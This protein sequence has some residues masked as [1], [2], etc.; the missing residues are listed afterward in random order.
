MYS[1]KHCFI[2]PL[3]V[4]VKRPAMGS[5]LVVSTDRVRAYRERK[6]NGEIQLTIT[7][8]EVGLIEALTH[9]GFISA[10]EDDPETIRQALERAVQV[11]I[12]EETQ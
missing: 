3:A 6:R 12:S 9:A 5:A 4:G 10:F 11:W 8:N 1:V 7:C 2:V